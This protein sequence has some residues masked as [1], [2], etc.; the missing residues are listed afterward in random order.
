MEESC[1][2]SWGL[3]VAADEGTSSWGNC[4]M[5]DISCEPRTPFPNTTA[6]GYRGVVQTPW[7]AMYDI[8]SAVNDGL[9]AINEGIEIGDG[10]EHNPRAIA[11][12]RFTQ[13]LAHGYLALQF[14]RA[15]PCLYRGNGT[16]DHRFSAA[17]L[18]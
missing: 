4:G 16:G 3:G 6:Y 18:Q 1:H 2:P 8:I 11:F 12:A 9:R 10:G 5:Q 17:G 14:D 7:Y 13:G 15:F